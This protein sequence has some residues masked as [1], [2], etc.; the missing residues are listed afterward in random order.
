[1]KHKIKM[2]APIFDAPGN[3][4]LESARQLMFEGRKIVVGNS[5]A[6]AHFG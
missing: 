5:N 1:M 4:V 6:R 3:E 2:Q